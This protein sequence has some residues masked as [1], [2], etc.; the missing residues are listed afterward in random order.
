MKQWLYNSFDAYF[1][2]LNPGHL[3]LV[4]NKDDEEFDFG[5]HNKQP[6][7]LDLNIIIERDAIKTNTRHIANELKIWENYHWNRY[8]AEFSRPTQL[9]HYIVKE[10]TNIYK[11][12]SEAKGERTHFSWG[13][14]NL[15]N[16]NVV[17]L[18]IISNILHSEIMFSDKISVFLALE[19][20]VGHTGFY[21][22]R[23][24]MPDF[25]GQNGF[26]S[27]KLTDLGI[28]VDYFKAASMDL[29]K[30]TEYPTI[31]STFENFTL[32]KEEI[33]K[34]KEG[35]Y[36]ELE[37]IFNHLLSTQDYLDFVDTSLILIGKLKP[38]SVEQIY[39][40][41]IE[42]ANKAN[43]GDEK[44][45]EKLWKELSKKSL[46]QKYSLDCHCH[47]ASDDWKLRIL[48]TIVNNVFNIVAV[49]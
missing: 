29:K 47:S 46:M 44:A 39:I 42:E 13:R 1:Q 4:A 9:N 25:I 49:D 31:Y 37:K 14:R 15:V 28:T 23:Q 21:S 34:I 26:H 11:L 33:E 18:N 45:A 12:L 32:L 40:D 5:D 17:M 6:D 7:R 20:L 43:T 35:L 41:A 27:G 24:L 48:S 8:E 10:I 16:E 36:D 38:Y 19:S 2:A 30:K 3:N 22:T